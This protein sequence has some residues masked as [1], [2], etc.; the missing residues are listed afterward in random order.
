M[1]ALSGSCACVPA[2]CVCRWWCV[3]VECVPSVFEESRESVRICCLEAES[4]G[5]RCK[6]CLYAWI[7]RRTQMAHDARFWGDWFSLLASFVVTFHFAH[8]RGNSAPMLRFARIG[9]SGMVYRHVVH[10]HYAHMFWGFFACCLAYSGMR[11]SMLIILDQV[12]VLVL[13]QFEL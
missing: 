11:A 1:C 3:L 2:W 7:V 13:F 5:L 4:S 8:Q 6:L 12:C 10:H 9:T